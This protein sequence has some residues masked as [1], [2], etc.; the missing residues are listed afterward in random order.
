MTPEELLR[1]YPRE[2]LRWLRGRL[3][4]SQ[5]E[6]GALVAAAPMTVASWEN[7]RSTVR[8]ARNRRRIVPLLASHL[9]TPEG[10]AF[11][12]S[13]GCGGGQGGEGPMGEGRAGVGGFAAVARLELRRLWRASGKT[14]DH[15]LPAHRPRNLAIARAYL[16]T[17]E[18]VRDIAARHGVSPSRVLPIARSVVYNTLGRR[19]PRR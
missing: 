15:V 10:A 12:Q 9:A 2:T 16:E 11:V 8:L 6:M 1:L 5:P 7:G 4:L 3:G 18:P 14:W 13:L 17:G 19:L